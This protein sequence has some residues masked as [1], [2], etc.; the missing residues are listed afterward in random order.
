MKN[1]FYG[2]VTF[3][4]MILLTLAAVSLQGC[5]TYNPDKAYVAASEQYNAE[6][7]RYEAYYQ[8]ATPYQQAVYKD[9]I[10]PYILQAGEAL[11]AWGLARA[12]GSGDAELDAYLDAKNKMIDALAEIYADPPEE[13]RISI[14]PMPDELKDAMED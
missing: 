5:A 10:D 14:D 12:I 6:V 4:C 9:K 11:N 13:P 1:Y 3:T 2:V 8:A 7:A